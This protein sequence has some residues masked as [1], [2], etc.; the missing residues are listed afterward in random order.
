M[1]IV[2]SW[3]VTSCGG[4]DSL[5]AI[6]QAHPFP[7][8]HLTMHANGDHNDRYQGLGRERISHPSG[9]VEQGGW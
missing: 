5:I 3:V 4:H 7:P 1:K 6:L 8:Q 9:R 2:T